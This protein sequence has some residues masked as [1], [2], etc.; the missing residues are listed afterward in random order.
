MFG[1]LGSV[2]VNAEVP[3]CREWFPGTPRHIIGCIH[4]VVPPQFEIGFENGLFEVRIATDLVSF[5]LKNQDMLVP[6]K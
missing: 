4:V 6:A 3:E 1:G 5:I 2:L